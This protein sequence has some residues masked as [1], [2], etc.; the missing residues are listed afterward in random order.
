[1][2]STSGSD[3][4]PLVSSEEFVRDESALLSLHPWIF[5]KESYG[6]G[7]S[8]GVDGSRGSLRSRRLRRFSVKPVNFRGNY[9]GAPFAKEYGVYS[10]P[11]SPVLSLG[12]FVVTDGSRIIS[13]SSFESFGMRHENGLSEEDL[14]YNGADG[15]GLGVK[16]AVIGIPLLPDSR[17]LR[18]KS[19]E[20]QHGR[21]EASNSQIPCKISQL[22]G[23]HHGI[24]PF[25]I[26]ISIGMISALL[27]KRTE[28][29]K[30]NKLLNQTED[31]VQDLQ[32]E[33][34]MKD[35]LSVKELAYGTYESQKLKHGNSKTKESSGLWQNQNLT[36]HTTSRDE[37]DYQ[38]LNKDGENS[39]S[40]RKIEAELEAELERLEQN[41]NA[42]SM[43]QRMSD[44]S[45]LNPD[46]IADVVYGELRAD[47]LASEILENQVNSSSD[48]NTPSTAPTYN[49]NYAVS[50]KEVSLRLHQLIQTRL[51]AR[52]EELE[53][54]LIQSQRQLHVMEAERVSS[55][56]TFSNSDMGFSSNQES[57]RGMKPN[58][59][60]VHPFCLNLSRDALDAYDEAYEEFMQVAGK[61]DTPL[62]PTNKG[63]WID[64][65]KSNSPCRSLPWENM[66][67][68]RGSDGTLKYKEE[69]QDDESGSFI[70]EEG[71]MLIQ[72]LVERTKQ[73]SPALTNAQKML[74]LMD[75]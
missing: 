71:R 33:L 55:Q 10:P 43:E 59:V 22:E 3:R 74:L 25:C 37:C 8:A 62:S 19:S 56:R 12:P 70:D 13:R 26:G 16:R 67:W 40:L 32:E 29:D 42:C 2:A 75:L 54:E 18:R 66:L 52:I 68:S 1:M 51:E 5:K 63:E 17:K 69:D 35:S 31:L 64:G 28:V 9:I 24:L 36:P 34:E 47:N 73:G 15:V 72:Q 39:E 50:P 14:L 6:E 60:V 46:L 30:L 57:P 53:R 58:S 48:T 7:M 44:L 65:Y 11:N 21:V 41:M 23:T 45:E 4:E 38:H 27:L 49:A 61:E 20:L